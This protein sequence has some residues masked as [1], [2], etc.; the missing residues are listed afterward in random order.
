MLRARLCFVSPSGSPGAGPGC[1]MQGY[2]VGDPRDDRQGRPG[3]RAAGGTFHPPAMSPFCSADPVSLGVGWGEEVGHAPACLPE[4]RTYP[5]PRGRAVGV[6]GV[7]AEGLWR[8][9]ADG[10]CGPS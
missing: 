4:D 8:F 2:R 6:D 9:Q 5:K 1:H 10:C 3:L 7:D